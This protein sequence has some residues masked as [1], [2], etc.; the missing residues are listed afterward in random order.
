MDTYLIGRLRNL[1]IA[2]KDGIFALFE[3]IVNAIQAYDEAEKNK[4][5][6]VRINRQPVLKAG[7]SKLTQEEI[8]SIDVIDHGT[9]FND[10]NFDSFKTLDKTLKL[11]LG[12]K[13]VGRLFW[14]KVFGKVKI[15]STFVQEGKKFSR[16]FYF[17]P[18]R[19]VGEEKIEPADERVE[20]ETVVSL[21]NRHPGFLEGKDSSTDT[22]VEGVLSH[23][24]KYFLSDKENVDVIIQDSSNRVSLKEE[25]KK[26]KFEKSHEEDISIGDHSFHLTHLLLKDIQ[27]KKSNISWCAD[28]RVVKE[29]VNGL[30]EIPRVVSSLRNHSDELT[31]VCLVE[32]PFLDERVLSDRTDFNIDDTAPN[33]F[34]EIGFDKIRKELTPPICN[35]LKDFIEKEKEAVID[36]LESFSQQYQSFKPVLDT[37]T[38]LP[39]V[40]SQ[41]S[42]T[43]IKKVL[44]RKKADMED[45][46]EKRFEDCKKRLNSAALEDVQGTIEEYVKEL[47]SEKALAIDKAALAQYVIRR[48]AILKCFEKALE[49]KDGKYQKEDF[50]HSLVIPMKCDSSKMYFD[51]ANLWLIDDRLAFH[52]YIA[53]DISLTCQ[54]ISEIHD[55]GRPDIAALRLSNYDGAIAVGSGVEGFI[56]LVE[57]KRPMRDDVLASFNQILRYAR[58]LTNGEIR[59]YKGRPV[60]CK[61]PVFGYIIADVTPEFRDSLINE[62]EFKE[63]DD[64]FLYKAHKAENFTMVV[65]VLSYDYLL[66]RAKQRNQKF[67]E[68][69]G[70]E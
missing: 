5:V 30:N 4:I 50:L 14:L 18:E 53:S 32:S 51:E 62:H 69:L 63:V 59:S 29:D 45:E 25:L 39:E 7:N 34:T 36:R 70:L 35:F 48:K 12:C 17:S 23:C 64:G 56:E 1:K 28:G 49:F 11:K 66:K 47:T 9:G 43:E 68:K 24:I 22:I 6:T 19:E 61:G 21:R 20:C 37:C 10:E 57:F 52:N 42:D 8:E 33:V 2:K 54:K 26:R 3:T 46:I 40:N 13:G 44:R 58:K 41:S 60:R 27:G 31:Y 65:E 16:S 15:K 38:N 55:N 67:F